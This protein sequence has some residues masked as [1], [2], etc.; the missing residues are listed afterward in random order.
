MELFGGPSV[1]TTDKD[2]TEVWMYDK[3]TSSVSG[4]YA[5]SGSQAT[6]SEAAAMGAFFGFPAFSGVGGVGGGI[7]ASSSQSAQVS[8]GTQNVERRVKTITFIIKF[9]ADKT[10]KD[11][12]VRQAS[13]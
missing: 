12:S 3:T 4:S 6:K 7:G 5:N 1:M 13:Y 11:Y 9:N 10:V 2:G 8:Q